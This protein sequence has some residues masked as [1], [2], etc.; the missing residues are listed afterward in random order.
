MEEEKSEEHNVIA[1]LRYFPVG[2]PKCAVCKE[3]SSVIRVASTLQSKLIITMLCE[4]CS[5]QEIDGVLER[6]EMIF[7]SDQSHLVS[8]VLAKATKDAIAK[9]V[10][11]Q[12]A[13]EKKKKKKKKTAKKKTAKKKTAKKKTKNKPKK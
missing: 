5:T 9:A 7:S 10:N 13:P 3:V 6:G 1:S 8:P 11:G 4:N 12:R 2:E